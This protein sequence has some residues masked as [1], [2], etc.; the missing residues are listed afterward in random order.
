MCRY[1]FKHHLSCREMFLPLSMSSVMNMYPKYV[2]HLNNTSISEMASWLGHLLRSQWR[3]FAYFYRICG[4]SKKG[5]KT[6]LTMFIIY[7]YYCMQILWLLNFSFTLSSS[8]CIC[9]SV[10]ILPPSQIIT[11]LVFPFQWPTTPC[12]MGYTPEAFNDTW[13][14]Q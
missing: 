4:I 6:H 3:E 7:N 13:I 12:T 10:H 9:S 8:H 1:L 14:S 11:K 2:L 5:N